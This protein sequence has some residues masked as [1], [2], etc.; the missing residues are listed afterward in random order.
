MLRLPQI[1][2]LID[3]YDSAIEYFV[4]TLEFSLIVDSPLGGGKR[5]VVLESG[6]HSGRFLLARPGND[7]QASHIGR[8]AGG[9]VAYFLYTTD[10]HAYHA[11]LSERGV[12]FEESPR[13]E[14]YGWVCVFQD[15][16][17]NRWDLIEDLEGQSGT[18]AVI[19][20]HF[21]ALARHDVEGFFATLS[22]DVLWSTGSDV[23]SGISELRDLF[24]EGFWSWKPDITITSVVVEGR[25][26]MAEIHEVLHLGG[27]SLEFDIAIALSV[28]DGLISSVRTYRDGSHEA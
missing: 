26:A 22:P 24:D 1:A 21:E 23:R 27:Q 28:D 25:H 8:A 18:R 13:H 19:S 20:R 3:E 11:R 6:P 7:E 4:N 17:G 14:A 9:R 16:F 12:H 15:K 10:F 5:W 2:F